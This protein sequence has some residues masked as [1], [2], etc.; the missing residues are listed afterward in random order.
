MGKSSC[1]TNYTLP[2]LSPR[3]GF[4]LLYSPGLIFFFSKCTVLH[5]VDTLP[6]LYTEAELPDSNLIAEGNTQ[7]PNLVL[8]SK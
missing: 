7:E 3:Y 1:H 5:M 4:R 6:I 8:L 2:F